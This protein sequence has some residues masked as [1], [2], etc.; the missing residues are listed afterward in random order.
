MEHK[1]VLNAIEDDR[2]I[3]SNSV[4]KEFWNFSKYQTNLKTVNYQNIY[5]PAIATTLKNR[6]KLNLLLILTTAEEKLETMKVFFHKVNV[7]DLTNFCF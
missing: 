3:N 5:L 6:I 2:R 4:T 7:F 1:K